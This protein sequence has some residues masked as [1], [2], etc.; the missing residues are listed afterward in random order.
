MVT[1]AYRHRR[2]RRSDSYLQLQMCAQCVCD[3][4][5][6]N[7]VLARFTYS[8]QFIDRV[9]SNQKKKKQ[10]EKSAL[11]EVNKKMSFS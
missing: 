7:I 5:I 9:S 1:I 6:Q 8:G 11:Y 3:F 10:E 2:R 4:R